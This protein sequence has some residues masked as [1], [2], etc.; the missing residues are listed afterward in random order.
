MKTLLMKIILLFVLVVSSV[1]ICFSHD[2]V[3]G[4]DATVSTNI[5]IDDFCSDQNAANEECQGAHCICSLSCSELFVIE[6]FNQPLNVPFAFLIFD[7]LFKL[8]FYPEIFIQLEKP[9]LV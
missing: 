2:V 9:P 4:S 7:H 1:S 6:T 8:S 3:C 5:K